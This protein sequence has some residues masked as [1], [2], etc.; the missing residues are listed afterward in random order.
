MNRN[1][2]NKMKNN[3]Q[4]LPISKINFWFDPF[5]NIFFVKGIGGI[6]LVKLPKI[7]FYFPYLKGIHF[8]FI[9]KFS[10]KS[11]L[12]HLFVNIGKLF[13]CFFAKIK[14]R[15]LGYRFR[16]MSKNLYRIFMGRTNFIYFHFP[17]NVYIKLRRRLG[18]FFCSDLNLLR[19]LIVH[20]LLL[21]EW[22]PYKLSGVFF[23]RQLLIVKPGKKRF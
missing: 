11:F 7:Y 23:P 21:K 4:L 22:S 1:L 2:V 10:F 17:K 16:K 6:F 20:F 5:K 15:G 19:N 3:N 18:Y 13:F 14:L 9:N 12:S 8:L